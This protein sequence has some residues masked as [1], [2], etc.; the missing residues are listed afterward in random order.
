MVLAGSKTQ[1]S[2]RFASTGPF[3]LFEIEP[4]GAIGAVTQHLATREVRSFELLIIE[5]R[6]TGTAAARIGVEIDDAAPSCAALS[7]SCCP[8]GAD[9]PP[10]QGTVGAARDHDHIIV[11]GGGIAIEIDE[12]RLV[13]V[14]VRCDIVTVAL[15][16]HHQSNAS[17]PVC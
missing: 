8:G 17:A 10:P 6:V 7:N 13:G 3:N 14:D 5:I 9:I 16:Y 12:A 11:A 1:L 4:F 15:T 2:S